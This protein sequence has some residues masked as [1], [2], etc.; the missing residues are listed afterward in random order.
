[1]TMK[2]QYT[3]KET[4]QKIDYFVNGLFIGSSNSAPFEMTFVPTKR[5]GLTP[6]KAV[7][8]MVDGGT[9]TSEIGVSVT[10]L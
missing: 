5:E 3:G 6:L 2:A 10:N 7:A 9:I 1:M 4:V 8:H